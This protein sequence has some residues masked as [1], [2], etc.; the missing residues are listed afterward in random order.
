MKFKCEAD[1][2]YKWTWLFP[3][4]KMEASNIQD[5]YF[6]PGS[7]EGSGSI[8]KTQLSQPGA[9][10]QCTGLSRNSIVHVPS[11]EQLIRGW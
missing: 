1:Q 6:I 7:S 4:E 11:F 8:K 10:Y 9:M 3:Q 5:T 2:T